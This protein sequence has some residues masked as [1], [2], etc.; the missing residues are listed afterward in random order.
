MNFGLPAVR[1]GDFFKISIMG[2]K[3]LFFICMVLTASIGFIGGR[4][5][6]MPPT[7][8]KSDT[9]TIRD[10]FVDYKPQPAT[11]SPLRIETCRLLLASKFADDTTMT[12]DT[13]IIQIHDTVAVEVPITLSRYTARDYDIAVSGFRTE[14]EHVKVFPETKVVT[15]MVMQQKR[16]L[17]FG[18]SAGPT[19]CLAPDGRFAYGLGVTGGLTYNF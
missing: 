9:V 17:G 10:T 7:D 18:V 19:V 8:E 1:C 4:R 6:V 15:K 2:K 12:A 14:L 16:K 5:S 3:L 11:V 13:V